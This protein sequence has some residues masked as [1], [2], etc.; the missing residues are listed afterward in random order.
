MLARDSEAL[1]LLVRGVSSHLEMSTRAFRLQGMRVG[2][3]VAALSGQELR[4]EE[5]DGEREEDL[6]PNRGSTID[7]VKPEESAGELEMAKEGVE[8][9][10]MLGGESSTQDQTGVGSGKAIPGGRQASGVGSDTRKLGPRSSLG[11]AR[12]QEELNPDM[13]LPLGGDRSDSDSDSDSEEPI[14]S[15]LRGIE[16]GGMNHRKTVRPKNECS[17]FALTTAQ[18]MR[19]MG[20][21][22]CNLVKYVQVTEISSEP[23]LHTRT[24][25]ICASTAP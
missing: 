18:E 11:L 5:L 24:K 17:G 16:V 23:C 7:R 25:H 8:P 15:G 22:D 12:T 6:K 4:F 3:V 19:M 9:S 10:T 1:I 21:R 20:S 13:P 14:V 2:E